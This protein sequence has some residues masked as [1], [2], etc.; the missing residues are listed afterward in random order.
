[1]VGGDRGGEACK[2]AMTVVIVVEGR[3][4]GRDERAETK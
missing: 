1:V 3:R 2:V 4:E